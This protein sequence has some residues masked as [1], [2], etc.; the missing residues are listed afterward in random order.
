MKKPL[1]EFAVICF[2]LIAV[3]GWAVTTVGDSNLS[4]QSPCPPQPPPSD[5]FDIKVS[6]V[7]SPYDVKLFLAGYQGDLTELWKK[8]GIKTI[9]VHDEQQLDP[10]K[11]RFLTECFN[12]ETQEFHH[13]L[14]GEPGVEVIIKVQDRSMEAARYLIF[15]EFDDPV[16]KWKLLG[17]LDEMLNKYRSS[18]HAVVTSGGRS[19]L[20]ITGQG[21]SGIGVASYGSRMVLVKPD[22]LQDIL[23]Y[24]NDGHQSRSFDDPS[25]D[26]SANLL[27]CEIEGNLATT[28]IQF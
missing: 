18:Q 22:G 23:H 20:I 14:D 9:N 17:H 12:C 3:F 5:V 6:E 13:D 27:S 25:R 16:G 19:L 4:D 11:W 28:Q 26:F 2:I 10:G 7:E 8:L 1:T 15:K 24:P 21:A